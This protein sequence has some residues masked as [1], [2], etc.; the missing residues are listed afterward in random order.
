[1]NTFQL[2]LSILGSLVALASPFIILYYNIKTKNRELKQ[3]KELA[4]REQKNKEDLDIRDNKNDEKQERR[5]FVLAKR[6]ETIESTIADTRSRIDNIQADVKLLTIKVDSITVKAEFKEDF[7]KSIKE[8][9]K[10]TMYNS[11]LLNPIYKSIVDYFAELIEKYGLDYHK[12]EEKTSGNERRRSKYL[13]YEK[14][15]LL[16]KFTDYLDSKID[17]LR[18]YEGKILK[19][20]DFIKAKKVFNGLD[21]LSLDL[22]RNGID[23][24]RIK[25]K[26]TDY[27]D[28][29]CENFITSTVVWDNLEKPKSKFADE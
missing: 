14:E 27:I 3:Q 19:F 7:E 6:L 17:T 5:I 13:N 23:D 22:S 8:I 16:D 15:I 26:F 1:M 9:S 11:Y 10:G 28:K 29:F 2:V 20:S 12:S 4:L 24:D 25:D 18:V 21:L